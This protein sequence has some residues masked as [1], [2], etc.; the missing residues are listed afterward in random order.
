M[1]VIRWDN[2]GRELLYSWGVEKWFMSSKNLFPVR[3]VIL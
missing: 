1:W 2:V 3:V